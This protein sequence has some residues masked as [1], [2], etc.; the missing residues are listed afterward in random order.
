M[1]ETSFLT[2]RFRF[3]MASGWRKPLFPLLGRINTDG[4]VLNNSYIWIQDIRRVET[5][6]DM[7]V[8]FL[9]P[10][11]TFGKGIAPYILK[12]HAAVILDVDQYAAMLKS[13]INKHITSLELAEKKS[14]LTKEELQSWFRTLRCPSCEVLLDI[15]G[16]P[17]TRLLYCTYCQTLID[18]HGNT[19]RGFE[20]YKICPETGFYDRLQTRYALDFYFYGKQK[21]RFTFRE[22]YAGDIF[23]ISLFR[24]QFRENWLYFLGS[25]VALIERIKASSDR[26][27][28]VD[29]LP[30]AVQAA[31]S[32]KWQE[33]EILF[34]SMLIRTADNPG[35]C[36]NYSLILL[37]KQDFDRAVYYLQRALK[38]CC[39]YQPAI[40]LLKKYQYE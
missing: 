9:K 16:L 12:G 1:R 38:T 37:E 2:F 13:I 34:E 29:K 10:Y 36:Y 6:R 19:L 26:M 5:H 23:A 27:L 17:E 30:E 20:C 40:N 39:N 24:K 11:S 33:A 15:S 8:I 22:Y 21:K 32:G 35:I 31:R 7:V 25:V 3:V 14:K 18:R 4:L 28:D